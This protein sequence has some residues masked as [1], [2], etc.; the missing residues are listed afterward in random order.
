MTVDS[1]SVTFA[2]LADPTRCAIL[3]RLTAGPA[4]VKQLTRRSR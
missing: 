3:V 4:T 1:L 2:A